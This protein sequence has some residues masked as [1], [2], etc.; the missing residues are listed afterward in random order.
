VR[1]TG[2]GATADGGRGGG[3]GTFASG[4]WEKGEGGPPITDI[5]FSPDGRLLA[6]GTGHG[7]PLL[8][9]TS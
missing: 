1:S 5:K 4:G 2:A 9:L 6:V 7:T 8:S 3:D